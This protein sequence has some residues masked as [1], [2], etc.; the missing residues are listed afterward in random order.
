M[1]KIWDSR[2][3]RLA[4]FGLDL[5]GGKLHVLA[6]KLAIFIDNHFKVV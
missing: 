1:K 6:G 3:G 4:E 2:R 5:R